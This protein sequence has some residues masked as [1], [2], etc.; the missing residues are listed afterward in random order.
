VSDTEPVPMTEAQCDMSGHVEVR[1]VPDR[2]EYEIEIPNE[3]GSKG[4]VW[5]TW[6]PQ[7]DIYHFEVSGELIAAAPEAVTAAVQMA[8]LGLREHLEDRR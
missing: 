5:V 3:R 7:H 2:W 8:M 1:A 4:Y 6:K